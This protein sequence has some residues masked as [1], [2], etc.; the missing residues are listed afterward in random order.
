MERR[1]NVDQI[2]SAKRQPKVCHLQLVEKLIIRESNTDKNLS[3]F[4][5]DLANPMKGR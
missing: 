3:K 4:R 1:R 2:P 5:M